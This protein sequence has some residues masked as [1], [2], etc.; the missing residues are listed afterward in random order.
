MRHELQRLPVGCDNGV[1]DIVATLVVLDANGAWLHVL[2]DATAP[3][4]LR[5][6]KGGKVSDDDTVKPDVRHV[7][8]RDKPPVH[9]HVR[10]GEDDAGTEG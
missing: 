9:V 8:G 4:V 5:Q 10:V 2:L 6:A 1:H 7:R 3:S